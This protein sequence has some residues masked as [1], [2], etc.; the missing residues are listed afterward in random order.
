MRDQSHLRIFFDS[1]GGVGPGEITLS[2]NGSLRDIVVL[3]DQLREGMTVTL[4][5]D[6]D[7]PDDIEIDA[8]VRRDLESGHWIS[9]PIS[10]LR[11][12]T[13]S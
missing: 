10:E 9:R 12:V 4:Y 8:I 11:Y 3:G 2:F 1:N 6:G 5:D 7:E 13:R